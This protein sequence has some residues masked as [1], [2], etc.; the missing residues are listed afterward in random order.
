[1]IRSHKIQLNP[2]KTQIEFFKKSCG[3]ARFS[4]NWALNKWKELYENGSKPSK[5]SVHK[6]LNSIKKEEFPWMCE[7]SKTCPQYA[8]YNLGDSFDRFFK[9]KSKYPKFKKKGIHDSFRVDDG[10]GINISGKKVKIP[11][12]GWIKLFEKLRFQGKIV[13]AVISLDVDKWFIAITVKIPD[14]SYINESQDNVG[15]DLGIKS[16]ATLSTGE[17]FKLPVSIKR[18]RDRIRFLQKS[19]S[20]KKKGSQ[21]RNK[22]RIKL[23][24]CY[25]KLRRIRTDCLHKLTTHLS[26]NYKNIVIEDL[27][28]SGMLKNRKLSR[29]ISEI[30]FYEFRRQLEYKT[31]LYDSKLFVADRFYPSSKLCSDC[32]YKLENLNLSIREWV[33]PDCGCFHNRDENAAINLKNLVGSY[34]IIA[35]GEESS[36]KINNNFVKLSSVK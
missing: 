32:G 2:N 6:I 24:K 7:V 30:G 34:S 9:K 11:K 36:G 5:Y 19:L 33:C 20:R 27:N 13:Q 4:Y 31:K 25:R 16:L 22:A 12:L 35:Y 23:A 17:E 21:N 15:V 14:Y 1:M 28:V 10:S 8:I 26:K 29:T 18:M 3:T